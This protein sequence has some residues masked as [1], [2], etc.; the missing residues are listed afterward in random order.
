PCMSS[1]DTDILLG[2]FPIT[3]AS[4]L[5]ISMGAVLLGGVSVV[6]SPFLSPEEICDTVNKHKITSM[7]LFSSR[8]QALVQA[9]KRTGTRL[10]SVRRIG[11]G[12]SPLSAELFEEAMSVFERAE[13]LMNMYGLSES[14][15][16]ICSPSI[17]GVKRVDMGFPG[18][19]TEIRIVDVDTRE[20]L[21]PNKVGELEFRNPCVMRGYYKKPEATAAFKDRDGWCHSG[22]LAYYDEDGRFYFVERIKEMIKCMDNQVVPAE[23]EG[24]LMASHEGIDDVAVIG[25]P[26]P[27]YGEAPAA[28]VVLNEQSKVEGHVTAEDIRNIIAGSLRTCG[29]SPA[30]NN[31]LAAVGI[32]PCDIVLHLW[33][34]LFLCYWRTWSYN[35]EGDGNFSVEHIDASLCTHLV[36]SFAILENDTIAANDPSL[37]L[38]ENSGLGM[39]MKFNDLKLQNPD[40]MTI[41]AIGGWNE[42]YEKYSNMAKTAEGRKRFVNSVLKF[43][44]RHGFD[45][46]DLNWEYPS[47]RGGFPEDRENH[48]LLLKDLRD[49]LDQENRTLIASVSL[50]IKT[51][52]MSYNVPEVTKSVH[53]LNVM[54][55]DFYGPWNNYTG[56]NSPLRAR[57][58]GNELEQTMNVQQYDCGTR[59]EYH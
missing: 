26:H 30:S 57:K 33:E 22:D 55:Y 4:G 32:G 9:M 1:D 38:T 48:A 44:D 19:M 41:I 45:G 51:V 12:G 58:G 6:A 17:R 35:R 3:H 7:F 16:I 37:D 50:K 13:C 54:G 15:S 11:V 29:L 47:R 8:L 27:V 28:V 46:L 59:Y 2:N 24:L 10:G 52:S 20:K 39:Y 53:V 42:G 18:V 31:W 56:H 25:L 36:Y 49:A 34:K 43:L 40:L 14:C 21:G 5:M 23:L